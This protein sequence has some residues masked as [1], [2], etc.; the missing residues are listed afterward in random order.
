M[1]YKPHTLN[2]HWIADDAGLRRAC[3]QLESAGEIA[4]DT[5]FIRTDTFYPRTALIQ[6]ADREHGYLVDPLAIDDFDPLRRLFANRSV[7]KVIHA[8]SEDLEVFSRF[9]DCI[10][11]PLIDTQLAA[12]FL[13]IGP[14]LGYANL[15][16][17]VLNIELEK[18]VTRSDWLQRPLTDEQQHYAVQ[19][20]EFLLP[21]YHELKVK[22]TTLQRWPWLQEDCNALVVAAQ[23]PPAPEH[24]YRRIKS[25]QKLKAPELA[26]LQALSH[27][28]EQQARQADKPRNRIVPEKGLV[29]IARRNPGNLTQLTAVPEL[30]PSVVRRHG[31]VLLKQ[32]V[33]ANEQFQQQPVDAMPPPLNPAQRQL[34]KQLKTRVADI[35]D[36][37][38]MP[39]EI[40][41]RKNDYET[42]I[43]ATSNGEPQLPERWQGWRQSVVGEPLMNG[44]KQIDEK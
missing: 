40:L 39:P 11:E 20:V 41:A 22:L 12:A 29:E 37:I 15:V 26:R 25:V 17:E 14:G 24:Y 27:W 9:L 36:K 13:N 7:T 32:V 4:L 34:L 35:A 3:R 10:P 33:Q 31:D 18:G 8:C 42:M 5:E 21:V 44:L 38:Q 1:S 6:L 43:R 19:D 2:V 28:R 23:Q 16:R 30:P